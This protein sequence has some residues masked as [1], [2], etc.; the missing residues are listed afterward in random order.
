MMPA[1]EEIRRAAR[2]L[3]EGGLVAFPTETVYG[4]GANALDSKAVSRVFEVKGRPAE[5]PLIVH[6]PSVEMARR[7][8]REWP[9][10][11]EVLAKRFWPGPLSVVVPKGDVVP[12]NVTAGLDTVA[13]RMPSHPVALALLRESG[14]PLAA[15]S[16]NRFTQL[17]PTAAAH[18]QEALGSQV[19]MILDGGPCQV[20]IE[21]TVVSLAGEPALLRP[22]MIT[23]EQL[24]E[25]IGV[26]ALYQEPGGA[27]PSPG[28]YKRHYSPRT[29]LLLLGKEDWLPA[30]RGVVVDWLSSEPAAYAAEL[31]RCLHRLDTEGYEWIA[32]PEPPEGPEWAAIRDRLHRAASR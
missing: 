11:A 25:C 15:P 31:Y 32:I 1:P 27:R 2:I 3:R 23:R 28:L 8:A 30:G 5:N 18:V 29:R 19:E 7:L 13:L 10:E 14:I 9:Q 26:V 22:G 4:L 17:S 12:A 21:S 24:E 20:G 16:A 6:V